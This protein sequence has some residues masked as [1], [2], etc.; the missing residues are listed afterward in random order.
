MG[1]WGVGYLFMIRRK[2]MKPMKTWRKLMRRVQSA[3]E[4]GPVPVSAST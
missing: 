4:T 3:L 2:R 1:T